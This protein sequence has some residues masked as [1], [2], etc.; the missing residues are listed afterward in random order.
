MATAFVSSARVMVDHP[1]YLSVSCNFVNWTHRN[2]CPTSGVIYFSQCDEMKPA[3]S[4]GIP[5]L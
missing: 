5:F 4:R 2:V 1:L 3:I